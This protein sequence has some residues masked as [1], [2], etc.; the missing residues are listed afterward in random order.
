LVAEQLEPWVPKPPCAQVV[1]PELS[2]RQSSMPQPVLVTGLH[3]VVVRPQALLVQAPAQHWEPAVQKSPLL[4][5]VA[6]PH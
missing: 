5:H 2:S 4:R 6:A 1:T 3:A